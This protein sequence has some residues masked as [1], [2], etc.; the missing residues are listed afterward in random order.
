MLSSATRSSKL[1]FSRLAMTPDPIL[2]ENCRE[3]SRRQPQLTNDS[4]N[5]ANHLQSW[6]FRSLLR[7]YDAVP[8]HKP[9]RF[10]AAA[11]ESGMLLLA[12]GRSVGANHKLPAFISSP[13]CPSCQA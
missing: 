11:D 4:R 1:E 2:R 5:V 7:Y 13:C 8:R 3:T 12:D 9:S 10:E 6:L